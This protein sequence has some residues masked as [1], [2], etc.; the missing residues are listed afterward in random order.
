MPTDEYQVVIRA[1]KIPIWEHPRRFNTPVKNEVAIVIVGDE[2][3]KRDIILRKR[4]G[5]LQRVSETYRSY[6]ALQYPLMFWQGQDGY[7]FTNRQID[8]KSK[9]PTSKKVSAMNF[10][11][12]RIMSRYGQV[13]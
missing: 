3:D 10:Y 11:A 13:N 12:Y 4:S 1:D 5:E 2:F 6:D 8:P 9:V 7:Q